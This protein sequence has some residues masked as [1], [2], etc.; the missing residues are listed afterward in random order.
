MGKITIE[1]KINTFGNMLYSLNHPNKALDMV[2]EMLL[3]HSDRYIV[4]T[5]AFWINI[6]IGFTKV[7]DKLK[8]EF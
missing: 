2:V 8:I 6:R 1:V 7:N 5:Y 4:P 3:N